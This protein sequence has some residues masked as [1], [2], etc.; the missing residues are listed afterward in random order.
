MK[1]YEFVSTLLYSSSF[2]RQAFGISVGNNKK[3]F[4]FSS[5]KNVYFAHTGITE[6][7]SAPSLDLS[8]DKDVTSLLHPS[9]DKD[10]ANLLDPWSEFEELRNTNFDDDSLSPFFRKRPNLILQRMYEVANTLYMLRLDWQTS[11]ILNDKQSNDNDGSPSSIMDKNELS[12]YEVVRASNL[13]KAVSS[14]GPFSVKIG[15]HIFSPY[16]ITNN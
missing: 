7:E 8:Y 1:V 3:R 4:S 5:A 6:A 11:H 9:S 16:F 12:H 10:E 15:K 2:L 13:C 14:L